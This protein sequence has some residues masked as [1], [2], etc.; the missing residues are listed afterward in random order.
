MGRFITRNRTL[1]FVLIILIIFLIVEVMLRIREH[2]KVKDSQLYGQMPNFIPHHFLNYTLN[3]NVRDH[4]S[5]G[6][7][8]KEI[9]ISKEKGMYRIFCLG[10]SDVYDS[11]VSLEDSYPYLLNEILKNTIYGRRCEVV[12]AGVPGYTS[13]N[14]FILFQFKILPLSP[15]MIIITAGFNDIFPRI[16][17][18]GSFDYTGFNMAW[19]PVSVLRRILFASMISQ[20]IIGRI[21]EYL[22]IGFLTWPPH[23]HELVW[24]RT[25]Q[26]FHSDYEKNFKTTS[27]DVFRRNI[28]SLIQLARDNDADVVLT[29]QP[30]GRIQKGDSLSEVLKQGLAEYN[31]VIRS[32]AVKEGVY[33]IDLEKVFTNDLNLFSD[34]IHMNPG[35]NK[36]RAKIISEKI[37]KIINI[38]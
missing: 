16:M 14:L 12:N 20:K 7:R 3:P 11:R 25:Y 8:G 19:K 23:I 17:G 5:L 21:G 34:E 15:D 27:S 28:L 26:Y 38:K 24:Q 35:G 29:T 30:L 1:H 9:S 13:A 6:F 4:N 18:V 33:L 22:R 37:T 2:V 32:L 36:I 10:G 31:N